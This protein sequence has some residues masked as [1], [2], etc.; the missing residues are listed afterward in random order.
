MGAERGVGVRR[1]LFPIVAGPL[2]LWLRPGVAAGAGLAALLGLG[3]RSR[4]RVRVHG[5]RVA[6]ARGEADTDL[7]W[8][9]GAQLA[10]GD[11]DPHN[12]GDGVEV[13][14]PSVFSRNKPILETAL[15]TSATLTL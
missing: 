8:D 2:G 7:P 15:A 10:V 11:E 9:R 1:R 3:G 6:G 13:C 4:G 12:P 5:I 14:L